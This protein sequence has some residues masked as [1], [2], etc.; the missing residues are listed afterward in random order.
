MI[1]RGA[2]FSHI[3]YPINIRRADN[4]ATK[5]FAVNIRWG[6][7]PQISIVPKRNL[8]LRSMDQATNPMKLNNTIRFAING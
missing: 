6:S 1:S 5:N 3:L 7:I 4:V 2:L 8:L